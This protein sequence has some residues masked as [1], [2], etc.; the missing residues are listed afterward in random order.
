MGEPL[1]GPVF[2]LSILVGAL[3]LFDRLDVVLAF[4]VVHFGRP[5]PW[6]RGPMVEAWLRTA[7]GRACWA[8]FASRANAVIVDRSDPGVARVI[9]FGGGAA[10]R[11]TPDQFEAIAEGDF[12]RRRLLQILEEAPH[13]R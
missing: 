13:G 2:G 1:L 12:V 7:D 8:K 6:E 3:V 10:G 11:F 4:L 9:M 5:W